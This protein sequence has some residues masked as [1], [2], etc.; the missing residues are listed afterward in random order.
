MAIQ[1]AVAIPQKLVRMLE[2]GVHDVTSSVQLPVTANA[3]SQVIFTMPSAGRIT[4]AHVTVPN[5]LGGAATLKLQKRDVDSGVAV[6]LTT[7]T[8]AATAGIVSGA[9]L[10]PLDYKVGD[11]IE[12]LVGGGAVAAQASTNV[13]V[14][15]QVQHN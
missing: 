8:T 11:T 6:D 14:D 3:D 4:S 9:G 12:L 7:A 1:T 13:R 15:L 5:S 10:V 2:T